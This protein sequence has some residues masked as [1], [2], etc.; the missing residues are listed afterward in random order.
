[1]AEP[2]LKQ[3]K[4][5][6]TIDYPEAVKF[7]EMQGDVYWTAKEIKVEKDVQDILT[8]MTESEK[9][10]VI[11]VLK[12]FTLY[13]L[14]VGG[15]YWGDRIMKKFPR[16]DIQRMASTFSFVELG[17]H[18]PF[19]NKINEALRLN[20]DEFYSSYVNDPE[21]KQRMEFIDACLDD[22][23]DLFSLGVFALVEGAILYSNFAFLKHFQSKG[24]NK[25]TAIISG[26]NFSVRDENIHHEGGAWL[27]RTLLA[28]SKL[29]DAQQLL[30]RSR[31]EGAARIIREHEH[32]ISAKFFE[33]GKIEG[34]TDHQMMNFIDSRVNLCLKNLGYQNIF[35][36]TYN[37]IADWF[38]KGISSYV[39]HD[40]FSRG[41]REYNRNWNEAAFVWNNNKD[42]E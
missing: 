37:P 20:N 2:R 39:F 14:K 8:N 3:K 13:E 5:T 36:V 7:A 27:F 34:I 15:E 26:V 40:F 25:I 31:I 12:L 17:I 16:P 29:S 41:G 23:D 22:E 19:Y 1:M 33:K 9:H 30:L 4:E 24:K 6:Y 28:E 38:Y 42:K 21:L 10:G 35:E 18:A 11:T 32:L